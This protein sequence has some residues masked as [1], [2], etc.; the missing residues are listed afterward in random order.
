M[1]KEKGITLIGL[2]V[3]IIIILIIAG[4]SIGAT[5]G[6]KETIREAKSEVMLTNLKQVKQEMRKS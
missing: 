5:Q 2:V 6:R 4:I 3:T 1:R